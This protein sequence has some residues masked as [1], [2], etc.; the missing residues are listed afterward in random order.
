MFLCDGYHIT[1]I[2]EDD[3]VVE[4]FANENGH[5]SIYEKRG[6]VG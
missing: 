4:L 3:T 1:I 5:V 6:K 2:L